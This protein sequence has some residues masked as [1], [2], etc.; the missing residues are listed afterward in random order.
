LTF[1]R[2][3]QRS[4]TRK[5]Q[6]E[7]QRQEVFERITD[8]F[9]AVDTDWRYTFVN[10]QAAA[11]MQ[12]SSAQLIGKSMWSPELNND[13][14]SFRNACEAAMGTQEPMHVEIQ[15]APSGRWF[16]NHIYP[17]NAG[18]SIY[19]RE[20]TA[21]KEVAVQLQTL[22][23]RVLEAQEAERRR[24][25]HE[26]HDELGQS[27]TAIKINL[28]AG[29][30]FGNDQQEKRNPRNIEIIEAALQHVRNLSLALRPS[31]LDDLGLRAA[32]EWLV[33]N[34]ARTSQIDIRLMSNLEDRRLDGALETACFR[35]VQEALTNIQRHAK[36]SHV[37]VDLTVDTRSLRLTV[38]D[39]GLGFNTDRPKAQSN[40]SLGLLGM[41]ERAELVGG[42]LTL[43]SSEGQG[44]EV[45]MECPL[46][47]DG[48]IA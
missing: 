35:V 7:Q 39:D 41:R 12:H 31:V 3:V 36:A 17:S 32:L 19:F 42:K 9:V 48:G 24:I 30:A 16:A 28:Q 2:S 18:A 25:A 4:V 33:D 11:I 40:K 34:A 20:T 26:L 46:T 14:P 29:A 43:T 1:A 13:N 38:R 47:P 37:T 23:R 44:C 10:A 45:R 8:A 22:S 27:L 21:Q 6:T 5:R 15:F